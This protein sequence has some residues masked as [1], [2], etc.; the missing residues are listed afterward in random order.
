MPQ[1]EITLNLLRYSHRYP[2]IS[3]YNFLNRTF[4]YLSTPL[5][6]P[7][8]RIIA[9]ITLS[10]CTNMAPHGINGWY[11]GPSMDHYRCHK[12][13][14]PTTSRFWDVLNIDW[15]PHIVPFPT[16][17]SDN[18]LR[19]TVDNMLSILQSPTEKHSPLNL[20]STVKNSFIQVSQILCPSTAP[21]KS[22]L[23]ITIPDS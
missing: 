16:V 14:I 20:G 10:Q 19:Q 23:P 12:C 8:T 2:K 15:F 7:G 3:A 9:N 21:H 13:Y 4:N 6:P 22:R 1:A 11:V 5:S 18:Y 17:T